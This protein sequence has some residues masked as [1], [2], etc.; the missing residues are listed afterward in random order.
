MREFEYPIECNLEIV[1]HFSCD[2]QFAGFMTYFSEEIL[3]KNREIKEKSEERNRFEIAIYNDHDSTV[4]VE[5]VFFVKCVVGFIKLS[6]ELSPEEIENIYGFLYFSQARFHVDFRFIFVVGILGNLHGM[7]Y[8]YFS[9]M[10][11]KNKNVYANRIVKNRAGNVAVGRHIPF[12]ISLIEKQDGE[13][14]EKLKALDSLAVEAFG[15]KDVNKYL[16][17][18]KVDG[19]FVFDVEKPKRFM[20]VR[21]SYN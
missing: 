12:S 10:S 19:V 9:M 4:L 8:G 7:S 13:L 5:Y 20:E 14:A 17:E 2:T 18:N 1:S 21:G 15:S 16:K 3:K 6:R 11:R